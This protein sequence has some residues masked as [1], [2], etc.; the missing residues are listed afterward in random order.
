M[1]NATTVTTAGASAP[2]QNQFAGPQCG[3]GLSH[4]HEPGSGTAPL[5]PCKGSSGSAGLVGTETSH[6]RTPPWYLDRDL[7]RRRR[8]GRLRRNVGSAGDQIAARNVCGFRV[9]PMMLTL[10]YTE[11]WLW[12]PLQVSRLIADVREWCRRRGWNPAYVWVMELQQRGAPHYHVIFWMRAD[13]Y[14]PKPDKRGW[15]PYGMTHVTRAR[16]PV[17]YLLKYVSKLQTQFSFPRGARIHG[18]GGLSQDERMTVR[19]WVMPRYQRARCHPSDAV[20]RA[21]GGGWTSS[22]TGEWWPPWDQSIP[23]DVPSS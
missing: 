6:T 14:L 12:D 4:W 17:G 1:S 19:W 20:V 8:L 22:V 15:W 2:S 5:D 18:R 10:T 13:L 11:A 3:T 7:Q 9:V 21:P 16:R 23:I